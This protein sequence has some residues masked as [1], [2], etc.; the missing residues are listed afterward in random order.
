MWR[1]LVPFFARL[2]VI[3]PKVHE[4]DVNTDFLLIV[5]KQLLQRRPDLKVSIY[6]TLDMSPRLTMIRIVV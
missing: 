3:F 6:I 4:R 5:L 2:T 1:L